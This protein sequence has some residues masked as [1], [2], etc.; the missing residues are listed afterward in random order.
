MF[1]FCPLPAMVSALQ[2]RMNVGLLYRYCDPGFQGAMPTITLT[3]GL[4]WP[5]ISEPPP[6]IDQPCAP[7]RLG[8]IRLATGRDV[9]SQ[10][11]AAFCCEERD[12]GKSVTVL[13]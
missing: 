5:V 2:D 10:R 7:R 1:E 12:A 13:V 11:S 9:V 6:P 8:S 4:D 3:F